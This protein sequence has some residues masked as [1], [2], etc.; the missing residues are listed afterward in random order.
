M[1]EREETR[2]TPE[3]NRMARQ[4]VKILRHKIVEMGFSCDSRGF[5]AL[6]ELFAHPKSGLSPTAI[7]IEDIELIV[8]TNNK[9]RLE[10][11]QRENGQY[12]LRAVQGH[13]ANV[14][15]LLHSESAF[16]IISEP[17]EFCAHGTE[18][19]YVD[20]IL[21]NGLKRMSRMHIHLVSEICEDRHVSGYKKC[22]NAV[23]VINM[24]QCMR[25]GMIFMRSTNGVILS[26]GFEGIIPPQYIMEVITR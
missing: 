14:G 1:V 7:S 16:E 20:S 12:Y 2:L 13:S 18:Q 21:A 4:L 23:V 19:K 6:D 11:E 17:L 15:E 10:L 3:L 5:V 9:K 26:E 25:D 8:E 24:T 22:S